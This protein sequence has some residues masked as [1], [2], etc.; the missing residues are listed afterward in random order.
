MIRNIS[1]GIDIGTSN[2][3]V[4]VGEFLKGEKY[5]KI[6]GIGESESKGVRHGYIVNTEETTACLKK[7]L[8]MAE[9]I[10]GIKIKRAFISMSS[11]T[12]HSEIISGSVV[13]S[14]ADGEI[15]NLDIEK[16]L[17]DSERNL[18]LINKKVIHSFPLS[19][20]LDGKEIT[21][22]P[23][24]MHGNKL[25]T[26][27]LF[28]TCSAQHL[29][30]L[31]ETVTDAGVEPINVT[32]SPIAGANIALSE[33]QKI[34]GS[35]LIDIGS[36]TVSL[37]VFENGTIISL[38]TF[39]IGSDDITKDIALG[40][41]IPLEKAEIIKLENS[42]A[43]YSKKKLNEIVDARLSDIFEL[44][45]NY[46]KKLKRNELLPAGVVFIGGGANTFNLE[47]LAKSTLKL[48]SKIGST[49][50]FGTTKTKLRDPSWFV[51]LG[52]LIYSKN[53]ENYI[54]GS[55]SNFIK[56]IKSALKSSI[57]QL[58]P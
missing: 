54:E 40:L 23:E 25:E 47:N 1:V 28:V 27:T 36:E 53:S 22:R 11:V 26:R 39:S 20:K 12:L 29:E 18:N 4:V 58:M 38:Q 8:S 17:E 43:E 24:G 37:A 49:E 3:R 16:V 10:S 33:K 34:V 56:D 21:G 57:K 5:P 2:I 45:E 42:S 52:L 14:K 41:R 7:A 6:V 48:P 35:A 15:T 46:L 32:A 50:I 9:K 13:V 30:D 31:L 19:Y 51:V 55:F 44:I